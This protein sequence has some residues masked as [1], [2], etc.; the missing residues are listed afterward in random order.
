MDQ[1]TIDNVLEEEKYDEEVGAVA[2][3]SAL[4]KFLSNKTEEAVVEFNN[5]IEARVEVDSFLEDLC[6]AYPEFEKILQEEMLL[7]Q[8]ELAEIVP[9]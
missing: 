3:E 8:N 5:Y 1:N 4:M 9:D 2:F 7:L 6:K